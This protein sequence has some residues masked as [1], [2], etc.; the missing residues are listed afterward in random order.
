MTNWATHA[1]IGLASLTVAI[2]ADNWWLFGLCMFLAGSMLV[3]SAYGW[4]LSREV[5]HEPY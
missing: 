5:D 2:T 1:A 4:V 3:S